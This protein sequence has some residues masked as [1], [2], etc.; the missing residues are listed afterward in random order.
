MDAPFWRHSITRAEGASTV[1]LSGELDMGDDRA[2]RRLLLHELRRPDVV[3]LAVD[4]AGVTS[5]DSSMVA[6]LVHA[7]GTARTSGRRFTVTRPSD[8]VRRILTV[9][10]VLDLLD[11][12]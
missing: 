2:V 1:A 3:F 10:G 4:L 11:T 6:A 12:A 8:R 5:L 9:T 7:H